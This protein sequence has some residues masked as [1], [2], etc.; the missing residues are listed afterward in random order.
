MR[1]SSVVSSYTS[2]AVEVVSSD[3]GDSIGGSAGCEGPAEGDE[4]GRRGNVLGEVRYK[5]Q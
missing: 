1:I 3:E 4:E 2:L 5:S